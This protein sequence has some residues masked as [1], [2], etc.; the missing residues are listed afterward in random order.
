[1]KYDLTARLFPLIFDKYAYGILKE[2]GL[3]LSKK[4]VHKEYRSMIKRTPE[5]QKDSLFTGNLLMGC[6]VLSFYKAY[7]DLIDEKIFHDLVIALCLSKPM[8]N[9]HRNEDAFDEKTL[10]LKETDAL[11][12]QDSDLEMDWRYTFHREKDHY[13]QIYTKCGLCQLGKR[14]DCFHL[15][16]YLCE[17]DLITY[18]LMKADLQ[19][20]M[21]I[22]NGD[23]CCDFH[24]SR[25]DRKTC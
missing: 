15:I 22:A 4:A 5:L 24:V 17:S 1:M 14:E 6:Y 23:E 12:S 7:P 20:T 9:G 16:R 13:D 3:K 10:K 18:D 11:R 25:K 2:K 21:T 19:R 8:V